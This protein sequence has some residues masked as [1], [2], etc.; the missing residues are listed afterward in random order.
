MSLHT[1]QHVCMYT[2]TR[3]YRL[4]DHS[5]CW[6]G[7]VIQLGSGRWGAEPKNGVIGPG[8]WSIQFSGLRVHQAVVT[9]GAETPQIHGHWI[10]R[11]RELCPEG[12]QRQR[13]KENGVCEIL[14][15][16]SLS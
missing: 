10:L 12:I 4:L 16:V 9:A 11:V 2:D 8:L 15:V 1:H 14:H 6:V 5:L 13:E 7:C 3:L